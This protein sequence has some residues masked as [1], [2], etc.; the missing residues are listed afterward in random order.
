MTLA[1]IFH[2]FICYSLPFSNFP[3][4][5]IAHFLRVVC[6]WGVFSPPPPPFFFSPLAKELVLVM[7]VFYGPSAPAPDG[8]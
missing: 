3:A 1:S 2:Q 6:V 7:V 8:R 4:F 5:L